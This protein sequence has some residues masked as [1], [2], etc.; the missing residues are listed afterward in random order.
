MKTSR[1]CTLKDFHPRFSPKRFAD[2]RLSS[3]ALKEVNIL[4][5]ASSG[6]GFGNIVNPGL[7]GPLRAYGRFFD[8]S[9]PVC[10]PAGCGD[11]PGP[12]R[13]STLMA[14]ASEVAQQQPCFQK[15][16]LA[17]WQ[18]QLQQLKKQNATIMAAFKLQIKHSAKKAAWAKARSLL[19]PTLGQVRRQ[20]SLPNCWEDPLH[21]AS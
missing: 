13:V 11:Q 20:A 10:D 2:G 17:L 18:Q 1:A 16:E 8:S 9:S 19:Q 7:Q 15:L 12:P 3:E 14:H 5:R 6:T 21:H 4:R